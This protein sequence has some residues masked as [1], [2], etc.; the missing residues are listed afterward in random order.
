MLRCGC[1]NSGARIGLQLAQGHGRIVQKRSV[2]ALDENNTL[3]IVRAA[4]HVPAHFAQLGL[5]I[6]T[7][8]SLLILKGHL[9]KSGFHKY[10][11][12]V[13]HR[14]RNDSEIDRYGFPDLLYL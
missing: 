2:L 8:T 9:Q 14:R 12:D 13:E 7:S 4:I 10:P 5:H 6:Y 3:Y 1:W 11:F